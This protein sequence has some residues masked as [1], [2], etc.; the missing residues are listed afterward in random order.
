M[1]IKQPEVYREGIAKR[2]E[3][4]IIW[5]DPRGFNSSQIKPS[6]LLKVNSQSQET[7]HDIKKTA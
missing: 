5:G 2:L 6:K 4:W 1:K 7:K 3:N